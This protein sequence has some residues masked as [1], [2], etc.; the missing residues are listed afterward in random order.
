MR[1]LIAAI[2]LFVLPSVVSCAKAQDESATNVIRKY[3][4][5]YGEVSGVDTAAG[6][7]TLLEYNY[8]L[9]E[10]ADMPYRVNEDT[11]FE[12]TDGLDGISPGDWVDIEY[13][14][15]TDGQR[16]ADYIALE[17]E[18]VLEEEIG[19]IAEDVEETMENEEVE[20]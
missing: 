5:L 9:D 4:A 8:D 14:T 6:T 1:I 13:S 16:K 11:E 10:E 3:N 15:D 17:K 20:E 12:F 18:P 7:I 19:T 2:F